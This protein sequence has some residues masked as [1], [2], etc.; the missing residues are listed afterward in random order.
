MGV[1]ETLLERYTALYTALQEALLPPAQVAAGTRA[2][3]ERIERSV[4]DLYRAI[5]RE[6]TNRTIKAGELEFT[7]HPRHEHLSPRHPIQR[8]E[9]NHCILHLQTPDRDIG[10]SHQDYGD[11]LSGLT[12]TID[13]LWEATLNRP[14]PVTD[15]I[16]N[17]I[18]QLSEAIALAPHQATL[19]DVIQCAREQHDKMADLLLNVDTPIS[20]QRDSEVAGLFDR[21]VD[22]VVYQDGDIALIKPQQDLLERVQE[23][24]QGTLPDE[25]FVVGTDPSTDDFF[26]HTVDGTHLDTAQNVSKQQIK[27][28]MGFDESLAEREQPVRITTD[29]TGVRLRVQGDLMMC[30]VDDCDAAV[31]RQHRRT[32]HTTR[33]E[34]VEEYAREKLQ[35]LTDDGANENISIHASMESVFL[36]PN[37]GGHRLPNKETYVDGVSTSLDELE[38]QVNT[39]LESVGDRIEAETE[40]RLEAE[41]STIL[42]DSG[43]LNVPI[44]NHLLVFSNAVHHP[45]QGTDT[46]PVNILV[47]DESSVHVMHDEHPIVQLPIAP[48]AYE[49]GLLNR[50]IQPGFDRPTW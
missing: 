26:V 37:D 7:Y 35:D 23:V 27:N 48:G 22:E 30:R 21:G 49:V 2:T 5:A 11:A 18:K 31:E 4:D 34:V 42:D 33:T 39:Y 44:D 8:L 15:E 17:H 29:D 16:D 6:P 13:K 28:A 3:S 38:Q 36:R 32:Q 47:P 50:G 25:A 12:E 41:T 20:L 40:S 19:D 1:K 14:C 45:G 9:Y 46:E 24:A 10:R 43:Q